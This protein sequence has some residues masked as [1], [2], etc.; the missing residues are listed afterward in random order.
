MS[1]GKR[2]CYLLAYKVTNMPGVFH[3]TGLV[4]IMNR[5]CIVNFSDETLEVCQENSVESLVTIRPYDTRGWHMRDDSKG[6]AVR[7]RLHSSGW[8]LGM[9]D[10][11]DI[12]STDLL[13]PPPLQLLK[14]IAVKEEKSTKE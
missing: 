14:T 1:N 8:S 4:T 9:V 10:V 13:L 12:G 7:F 2:G 3:R 11:N 5:Y 6:T